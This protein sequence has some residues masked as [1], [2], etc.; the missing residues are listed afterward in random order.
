MVGFGF[1]STICTLMGNQFG[2]GNASKAYDYY[3]VLMTMLVIT[4]LV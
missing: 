3:K 1:Q 2:L 4:L